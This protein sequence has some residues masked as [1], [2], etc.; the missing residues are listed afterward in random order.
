MVYQIL[1]NGRS[2][3]LQFGFESSVQV[4]EY[5]GFSIG[6]GGFELLADLFGAHRTN[7]ADAPLE[8]MAGFLDAERVA[9]ANGARD[10]AEIDNGLIAHDRQGH[11]Q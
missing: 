11:A 10:F 6:G 1:V 2:Q 9:F 4:G 7:L 5:C 8:A 3:G